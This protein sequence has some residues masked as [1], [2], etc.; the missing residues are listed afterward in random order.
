[1]EKWLIR[2][3]IALKKVAGKPDIAYPK[4]KIAIL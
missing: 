4:R 3:Q 1:M 2:I